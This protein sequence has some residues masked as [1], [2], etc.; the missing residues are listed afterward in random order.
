MHRFVG[1]VRKHMDA[2]LA[3][4]STRLANAI[5][6][7]LNRV[8]KIVKNRASGF[9]DLPPFSDLIM[10]VIADVDTPAQIPVKFRTV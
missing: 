8:A 9:R 5:S 10:L 1:T 2:I 4:T 7:G 3:F 6:E